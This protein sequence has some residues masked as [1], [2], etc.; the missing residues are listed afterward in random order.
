ME[1]NGSLA[2][3][4]LSGVIAK[5]HPVYRELARVKHYFQKIK[6]IEERS[7]APN[8][9]L[10]KDA[11]GRIIKHGLAGNDKYD[12][13]RAEDLVKQRARTHIRFEEPPVESESP[14][15]AEDV[16][17]ASREDVS[18]D[19]TAEFGDVAKAKEGQSR[20]EKTDSQRLKD[21]NR[22]AKIE[23]RQQKKEKRRLKAQIPRETMQ[24][25]G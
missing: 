21:E 24:E 4:R 13:E 1:F 25:D 18:M 15:K 6:G 10:D 3:L 9:V 16:P 11:A 19:D 5:D 20:T 2:Y 22:N 14:A 7:Q 8:K 12:A 23:R 17:S